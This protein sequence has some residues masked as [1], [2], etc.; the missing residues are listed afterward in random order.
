MGG[1][2]LRRG[3]QDSSSSVAEDAVPVLPVGRETAASEEQGDRV[4]GAVGA[5]LH[6]PAAVVVGDQGSGSGDAVDCELR[7]CA[8][9]H[10][11]DELQASVP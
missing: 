7:V 4:E 3:V 11:I 10:V 6:Q 5:T 8:R 2:V 1:A 9:L